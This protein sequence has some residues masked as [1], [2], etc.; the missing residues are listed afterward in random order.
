MQGTQSPNPP[1]LSMKKGSKDQMEVH[2]VLLTDIAEIV[3]DVEAWLLV[4]LILSV[5]KYPRLG[6]IEV[7]GHL[8]N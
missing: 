5:V 7:Y 8:I 4:W 6:C 1:I 3:G 2:Y